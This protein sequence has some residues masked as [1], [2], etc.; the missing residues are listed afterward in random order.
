MESARLIA[1][2]TVFFVQMVGRILEAV[3]KFRKEYDA[4]SLEDFVREETRALGAVVF[5]Y[6][7]ALRCR[8][9]GRPKS[10]PC[11]CGRRRALKGRAER[12]I[13]T[14]LGDMNLN[15]RFRYRCPACGGE[16]IVKWRRHSRRG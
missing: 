7:W 16:T 9:L 2:L 14:T 8:E 10:V 5:E 15:E 1:D 13:R 11:S 6:S 3:G 4:A 12:T